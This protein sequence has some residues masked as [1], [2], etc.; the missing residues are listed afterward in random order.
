MCLCVSVFTHSTIDKFIYYIA[1]REAGGQRLRYYIQKK[2]II[3]QKNPKFISTLANY[4][5]FVI[6][7]INLKIYNKNIINLQNIFL[8]TVHFKICIHPYTR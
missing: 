3:C 7:T 1:I 8:S 5:L 6:K 4:E 2:K